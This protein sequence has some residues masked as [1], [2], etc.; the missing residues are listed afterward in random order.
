MTKLNGLL[1]VIQIKGNCRDLH[2]TKSWIYLCL[3]MWQ[4]INNATFAHRISSAFRVIWE[5]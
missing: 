2:C 5:I 3:P 1:G 4:F